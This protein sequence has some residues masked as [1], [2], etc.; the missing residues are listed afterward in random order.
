MKA[1]EKKDCFKTAVVRRMG[2][3]AAVKLHGRDAKAYSVGRQKMSAKKDCKPMMIKKYCGTYQQ[4]KI[5]SGLHK[6]V[7]TQSFDASKNNLYN[8]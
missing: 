7:N 5:F 6:T 2:I 1:I 4:I 3:I 8:K